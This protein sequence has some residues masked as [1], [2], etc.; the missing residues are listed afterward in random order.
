MINLNLVPASHKKQIRREI[1]L[2]TLALSA[3]FLAVW[4]LVF[5][6]IAGQ[7]WLILSIQNDALKERFD[8]EE[9]TDTAQKTLAFE[10]TLKDANAL[11]SYTATIRKEPYD[12]VVFFLEFTTSLIPEGI[13]LR[14]FDLGTGGGKLVLGGKAR[15]REDLLTFEKR[16]K[17]HPEYFAEVTSPI[18]NVLRPEDID[19]SFSIT[20]TR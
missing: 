6:V 13:T 2:R 20:L 3:A 9:S 15:Y 1:V 14:S 4:T 16:L 18:S 11:L 8:V 19:F 12:D 17:E 5:F 7:A 10:Q